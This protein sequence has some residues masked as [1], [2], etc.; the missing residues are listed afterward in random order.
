MFRKNKLATTI[1]LVLALG[2]INSFPVVANAQQQEEEQAQTETSSAAEDESIERISVT[3]SRIK[4]TDLEP[5]QP[6]TVVDGEYYSDRG[7]TN[8]AD[9][10]VEI[11]GVQAAA[12]PI[13]GSNTGAASQGVGQNT[14]NIFGLGSQR[15]LTLVNGH[16]FVS[17]N[18]PVGGGSA[19]GSQVDVNNIPISLIERVEVV[20]VGGAAV[21]G[22]DAV[23]GVVNYILK[24]DYEGAEFSV[25]YEDK[26]GLANEI[27]FRSLIGGNFDSGRGNLVLSVEYNET[28]NVLSSEVPSLRDSWTLQQPAVADRVLDEDGNF[29]PGQLRLYSQPRAGILSFSGLVTPGPLAVTNFGIGRW[30]DGNFYQFS[31]DGSGGLVGYD[32]GIP[33][34]NA[35]WSS[36]GDGLDLVAT[37]TAQEGYERV[38]ITAIGNYKLTDD[39]NFSLTTFANTSDAANPGFQATQYSSGV[40]GGTGA[41]LRFSTDNPYL[42]DSSRGTLEN[43]LGGP[44]DFFMHR[45]WLN[46]GQREV[47]NESNV[48]SIRFGLDGDFDI[49]DRFFDWEVSYQKGVSSV[50]SQSSAVNDW[51]WLAAMDVGINPETG[52]IDCKFNYEDGYGEELVPQGNGVR[53]TESVLGRPGDCSPFNPFGT[54]SEASL[55]YVLYNSMGKTR[56]EQD[57]FSAYLTGELFHM[58]SGTVSGLFGI[59]SRREFASFQS[60]GTGELTG[61][62]DNSTSGEYRTDDVFGELYI[63]LASPGQDIPLVYSASLETSYRQMDSSRSGSDSAWAVGLN[64]RPI[65]D[66]IVRANVSETVRAPAITEL[67]LPR[68]QI[69]SFAADP[70]HGANRGNGPDPATRQSNC[71]AEGI[72][73]DFVSIATN[74]S[75]FGFTGGNPD[76]TNEQAESKNV[77]LIYAPSWAEGL[78]FSVDWVKIDISDA[79]TS[80]SL[81]NI[82]EACYDSTEYPN[83]FCDMFVRGP[84][85][86]LPTIDAFESGYVNAALRQFEAYEYTARYH[87]ALKDYP[88]IGGFLPEESGELTVTMRMY[89]L[90]KNATSNT[91]FDFADSTGQFNNPDWRGD[92]KITHRLDSLLTYVD[93]RYH[94]AGDRNVDNDDPLK[95][96]DIDGTPYS[97]LPSITTFDLGAVYDVSDDIRVRLKVEN[98]GD[99][100]PNRRELQAGRW[101]WGRTYNVG[102]N[103][104]F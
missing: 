48:R 12:T 7:L 94:G 17:S 45:G 100:Y 44:G 51:R 38:N 49:A 64:Y 20:K 54:A 10:V 19:P 14:I 96:I 83:R 89:N 99:W 90:K 59:E 37:N 15:T 2:I 61:F 70:C 77:G 22:S 56:V 1:Q 97:T 93:V 8:A 16:R 28:D 25:D 33:T 62:A 4:R 24:K 82:M 35:V 102:I 27:S 40:F 3:G 11:P 78:D 42:P 79:I 103:V 47:I 26:D 73:A 43:L 21:Y 85:F 91:G 30:G 39:V 52:A 23:A 41:A 72:P 86:Q 71:D 6:V 104:K 53:G 31:G 50:F 34:G 67:F 101:T 98:V 18:S 63:P 60:D 81:T 68:V 29:N 5:T 75:R 74:A 87:N 9:A 69:S 55:D 92:L 95:Y 46:F 84:D 32:P 36:G 66:L 88:L 76:L 57:I 65:E 80:F 13:I 58:S